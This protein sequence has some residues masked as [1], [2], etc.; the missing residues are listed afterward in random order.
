MGEVKRDYCDF[1]KLEIKKE[2]FS[3]A[4]GETGEVFR[5]LSAWKTTGSIIE[6]EQADVC[7][8]C[9]DKIAAWIKG[10]VA[11]AATDWEVTEPIVRSIS[12]P[13]L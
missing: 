9:Y 2:T 1:C 3:T 7:P 10:K 4:S 13:S 8:V 6:G 5:T 11:T 12:Y